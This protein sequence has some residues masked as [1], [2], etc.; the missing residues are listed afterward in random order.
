MTWQP[1]PPPSR[2][3]AAVPHSGTSLALRYSLFA[4]IATGTNILTQAAV[5]TVW[6]GPLAFW[7]A[8]AAGTVAG[9]VP[10][11]LLDKR[12]IFGDRSAGILPHARK[13]VLY[14]LMAVV[15]TALFW[16]IE[17]A[18]DRIGGQGWRYAGAVVGLAIGYF[19]KY[20]LDLRFV[21]GGER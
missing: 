17:F 21:F 6:R 11:Y 4:A 12:F 19:A 1:A 13:F 5:A 10:K 16:M 3:L 20:R 15:T 9:I 18:F 2:W 14:T 7:V 8:L